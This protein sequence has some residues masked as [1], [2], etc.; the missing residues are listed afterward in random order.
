MEHRYLGNSGMRVSAISYGNWLTHGSQVDD[1]AAIESVHAALDA[2]I[3]TFDTADVYAGTKAETVLGEALRGVQRESIELFTKV[4]FP[5]G[6]GVNQQGLSRKHIMES[7]EGSLRRLGTDHIDL[8]QAH[9]YDHRTPLE[10]TM[11]A[12]ADLVH[13]GKVAY[14]GVSEWTADQIR[15]AHALAAELK[16]PLVSNQPQY[17]LLWRV[18]EEEVVPTCEELGISQIVWSP[19]AQGALTGKYLPGEEPP[20]GSRATDEAGGKNMISRW[21]NDDVLEAVQQVVALADEA[22]MTAANLA[23][24]WVLRNPNVASAIVGASNAS[25]VTRNVKAIDVTLDDDLAVRVEEILAPVTTTDPG[26]TLK[27]QPKE[28]L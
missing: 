15:D 21:M 19:L 1:E 3:T 6:S 27:D 22:G 16:V 7:V 11:S 9:R 4:F 18:I 28:R 23:L 14:L 13:Q 2:G 17:S 25:Q 20:A 26:R 12:F 8:Y 10:V 5:T 24:A